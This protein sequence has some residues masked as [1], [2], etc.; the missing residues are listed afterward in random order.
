[1]PCKCNLPD[2]HAYH[3]HDPEFNCNICLICGGY[4]SNQDECP[5]KREDD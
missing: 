2:K 3:V 5:D 1:M 4:C